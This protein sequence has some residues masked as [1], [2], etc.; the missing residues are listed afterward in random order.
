MNKA[1]L[2][3]HEI[4]KRR[5]HNL[6]IGNPLF[7][8]MAEEDIEL[9]CFIDSLQEE[10]VSNPAPNEKMSVERWKKACDAASSD[11]NYRSHYG[12]TETR[13]DYFVDGVQWADEH[14]KEEPVSEELEKAA[15]EYIEYTPRYDIGYELEE[16]NDPTEIDCFTIDE[17]TDAFKAGAKWQKEQLTREAI[18]GIARPD[19]NEVWC[20][21]KS[22]NFKDGDKVKV[23]VIKE[24]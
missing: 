19:D 18:D 11:I 23:F 15:E 16:G 14:P 8:A 9:L 2:I 21:L 3:R 7:S 17:A 13:D 12:L 5:V 4:E 10:P 1:E 22:F 20:D 24:D 6:A